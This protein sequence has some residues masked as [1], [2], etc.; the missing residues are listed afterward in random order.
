MSE[1]VI[2]NAVLRLLGALFQMIT[3][4]LLDDLEKAARETDNPW[5][6]VFVKVLKALA[7]SA[8]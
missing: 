3:P 6:D 2:I 8:K 1:A 7:G 5:D 4:S